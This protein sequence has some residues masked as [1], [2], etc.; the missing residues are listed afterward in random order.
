MFWPSDSDVPDFI[1][2]KFD[3]SLTDEQK[4]HMNA[5]CTLP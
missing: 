5:I 4:S 1:K 3:C 2:Y